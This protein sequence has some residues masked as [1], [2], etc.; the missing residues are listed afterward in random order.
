[1]TET[2]SAQTFRVGMDDRLALQTIE[3]QAGKVVDAAR[4]LFQNI[5]DESSASSGWM[6]FNPQFMSA[7]DDGNGLE[8]DI[9]GT[10][11]GYEF[12]DEEQARLMTTLAATTKGE[13]DDT[14]GR[15]GVGK[16]Q[17]WAF[18]VTKVVSGTTVYVYDVRRRGLDGQIYK[19]PEEHAVDGLQVTTYFY[20][21]RVPS[22]SSYKWSRFVQDLK[23]RFRYADLE[24]DTELHLNGDR[25]GDDDPI[26]ELETDDPTIRDTDNAYYAVEGGNGDLSVYS[27]GIHVTDV[28]G[29]G[30][31]GVVVTH[32]NLDV[33]FA[34]NDIKDGCPVW[35]KVEEEL[36]DIRVEVLQNVDGEK[37]S[38]T[39]RE[40]A[41]DLFLNGADELGDLKMLRYSNGEPCSAKK[42][43]DAPEVGYSGENVKADKL[44]QRGHVV[45]SE[46][47]AATKQFRRETPEKKTFDVAQRA[48]DEGVNVGYESVS[49][50][51]VTGRSR[52]Y[53]AVA[54]DLA[55]DLG[56]WRDIRWGATDDED[57]M[58]WTDGETI[59]LT[60]RVFDGPKTIWAMRLFH[61]L[62]HESNHDSDTR[63]TRIHGK[64]FY[65]GLGRDFDDK[66]KK[67]E[68]FVR[69]LDDRSLESFES[70]TGEEVERIE[71][72]KETLATLS[73]GESVRIT[74]K[75]ATVE[76]VEIDEDPFQGQFDRVVTV[77]GSGGATYQLRR[78]VR[79]RFPQ[80]Q[81]DSD[82]EMWEL[83]RLHRV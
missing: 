22:T 17:A 55:H 37:M 5:I 82:G 59:Y 7:F 83:R 50:P 18:G 51:D 29:K 8:L 44:V 69:R 3:D 65:A 58:A 33:L 11:D 62:L 13:D 54:R 41:L 81:R 52:S 6:D 23:D 42:A 34:R 38:D 36:D 21:D 80:V 48:E 75:D 40:H 47:D 19:I 20:R 16:G 43:M 56:I 61:T 15:F 79:Q 71:T 1:M 2:D 49:D 63:E 45:L 68:N 4:E 66:M 30:L 32:S 9:R 35:A 72:L 76:V 46:S 70:R 60:K 78:K 64:E 77:A 14:I 26:D 74:G 53:L 10:E 27:N 25:I 67:F 12:V 28:D 57:R 73:V 39:A 31:E 24:H